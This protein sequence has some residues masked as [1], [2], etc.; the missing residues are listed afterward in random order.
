MQGLHLTGDLFGCN[1]PQSLLIDL[2]T[3]TRTC[4]EATQDAG[5]TIV[6]E[7]FFLFPD[8]DGEPGGI[9]GTLL[10]AESHLAIHTWP[11]RNGVTLDVYVC[12]YMSDNSGKAQQLFDTLRQHFQPSSW[13]GERIMR[14]DLNQDEAAVRAT[15]TEGQLLLEN[16]ASPYVFGTRSTRQIAD[17]Q[18]DYQRVEVHDTESFGRLF[19]LDGRF[20]TSEKDEFVYH[21]CMV[22]PAAICHPSPQR[23]LVIG[24]G[25]GGS[26]EELLKHPSMERV[27]MAELDG[28]VVE[29]AR[30]QL[31]SIHRGA[32]DDPRLEVRIGDGFAYVKE[33]T[34][35]FDLIVLDLTDPD[36]P[37]ERLYTADFFRLCQRILRPGGAITLHIGSPYFDPNTV[38]RLTRE[39]KE[40]FAIV[41]PMTAY[42]P[43]YGSLWGM[44]TA[45]DTL[46]PLTVDREVI[47]HRMAERKIDNLDYYDAEM[48]Q[49]LFTLPVY[50]RRLVA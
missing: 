45:S 48:H 21:E 2:E 6:D 31:G 3:L 46:D 18:S 39:L 47:A 35:T 10:L 14:G 5:L 25:D 8:V 17:F 43:L 42:V 19:R 11:E 29:M 13:Q 36:T 22:H 40:V 4:R 12:N 50:V 37:A 34:D 41:R 7:K 32:F 28:A 1:C 20:M 26:T 15:E 49:A 33:T 23:A 16:G 24:G 27:V 30:E 38:Q 9:T 44:A